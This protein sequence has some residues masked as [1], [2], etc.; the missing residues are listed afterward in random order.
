MGQYDY[1]KKKKRYSSIN[2]KLFVRREN[3]YKK[4][5]LGK[6]LINKRKKSQN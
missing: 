5:I 6:K 4:A 3:M 2:N 1:N